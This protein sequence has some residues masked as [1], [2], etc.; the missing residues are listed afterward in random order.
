MIQRF[1]GEVAG[2]NG[3]EGL[4]KHRAYGGF[5][6]PFKVPFKAHDMQ[7]LPDQRRVKV[8]KE[9]PGEGALAFGRK[10]GFEPAASRATIW[11][12]N[13]LSYNLRLRGANIGIQIENPIICEWA[14]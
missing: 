5:S 9:S 8:K 10:T 2:V 1:E 4:E 13:Q 6:F 11:R 12:S 7:D 3:G 14:Y